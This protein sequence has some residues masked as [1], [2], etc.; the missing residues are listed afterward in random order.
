MSTELWQ[1]LRNG[2]KE[3]PEQLLIDYKETFGTEAGKRVLLDLC[4]KST[5]SRSAIPAG[6]PIDNNRLLKDEAQRSFFLYII[7]KVYGEPQ[8]ERKVNNG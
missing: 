7:N 6:G 1:E 8:T 5:Y 3:D 2:K 4:R